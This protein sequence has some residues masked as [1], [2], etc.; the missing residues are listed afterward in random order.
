VL[1]QYLDRD[2][3]REARI[4]GFVDLTHATGADGRGDS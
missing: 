2:G 3:P 4:G 1:G